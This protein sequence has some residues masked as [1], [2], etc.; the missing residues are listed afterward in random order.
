[1]MID[2]YINYLNM[3]NS[4]FEKFFERQKPYIFCKKGCSYCCKNA[5]YPYSQIEFEYL[6][7]GYSQLS[8]DIKEKIQANI[9]KILERKSKIKVHP[10]TYECPFLLNNE[11]SVYQYRGII[12]RS[13]GLMSIYP[14][15]GQDIPFCATLG[16][17]Y[18]NVYDEDKK[19]ISKKMYEKLGI[20]EEPL[21]YNISYE[22]LTDGDFAKGYGFEFGKIQPLIDWLLQSNFYKEYCVLNNF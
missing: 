10:F 14:K 19:I 3:L 20:D 16:L 22:F 8:K 6:K 18:S 12:C 15:G 11:C 9:T 2:N 13:F 21:A 4:K 1:M 5:Q 17:N 7:M